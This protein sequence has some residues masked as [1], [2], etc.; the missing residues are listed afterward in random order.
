MGFETRSIVDLCISSV[1]GP[2]CTSHPTLASK[3]GVK[4]LYLHPLSVTFSTHETCL[5]VECCLTS[6]ARQC[7][8]NAIKN[9]HLVLWVQVL[10]VMLHYLSFYQ[11][12][13]FLTL[14]TSIGLHW[15]THWKLYHRI[16]RII[17]AAQPLWDII[18]SKEMFNYIADWSCGLQL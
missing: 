18:H 4:Q 10:T 12:N 9:V 11:W 3:P 1:L 13:F 6:W 8:L 2:A 17:L 15:T 5:P 7:N 14:E 16:N